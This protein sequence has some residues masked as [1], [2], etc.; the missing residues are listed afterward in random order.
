MKRSL[1]IDIL[2]CVYPQSIKM[3]LGDPITS[4]ADEKLTHRLRLRPIVI[5]GSTPVCSISIG[6]VILAKGSKIISI[7]TKMVVDNVKDYTKT[8]LVSSIN[9][10]AK[11]IGIAIVVCWGIQINSVIAP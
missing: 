3:K 8:Y 9:E 11:C 1:V 7:G 6:K 5:D 10:P 4:I 2:C